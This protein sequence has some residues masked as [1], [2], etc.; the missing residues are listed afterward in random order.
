MT[1]T[2]QYYFMLI[3]FI[4]FSSIFII[5]Y[6]DWKLK[7]SS[8]LV[9][10]TTKDI[11]ADTFSFLVSSEMAQFR[12]SDI[13]EEIKKPPLVK[14][15]VLM[16]ASIWP[17]DIRTFLGR[18]LI[19][20]SQFNTEIAIAG[21]GT[22]LTTLPIESE[23]PTDKVLEK[24]REA[25]ENDLNQ[26]EQ[27][28]NEPKKS[29]PPSVKE[30]V[31]YI[32]H[33]HSWEAFLPLLPGVHDI[34]QASSL[35]ENKNVIK[36]GKK[37]QSELL[38]RGIGAEHST[39]NVTEELKK[40]NW[41]Y[42]KSYDLTRGLVQE[43]QAKEKSIVY[44]IDIHRDSQGKKVT[45]ITINGKS[46][47]RLFFVVG[48]EN[49]NYETNLKLA[50]NLNKKLEEKL[51]GISRGVF[52]KSKSEGNGV[53]NQDLSSNSMLLEFGGVENSKKELYN[54][55]E[56]FSDVFSNYYK[57]VEEVNN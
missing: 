14:E 5:N 49:K 11:S 2:L 9:S 38:E 6:V 21:K 48:K 56:V 16:T 29:I 45:T 40:K 23:P 32:Y 53:Y 47:A 51:P 33:S 28:N 54:T 22:D 57:Q 4:M 37:L 3:F 15:I 12:L 43:V 50:K 36:V 46:Y 35:N 20:F 1:R 42:Y 17:N 27:E 8:D 19:G 7:L 25:T 34:N 31:V 18:E 13:N 10:H 41:N 30:N 24:D 52:V 55:I 39:A 44:L 26:S